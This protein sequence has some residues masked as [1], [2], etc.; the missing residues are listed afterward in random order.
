MAAANRTPAFVEDSELEVW[1]PVVGYEDRYHVS[2]LGR[3]KALSCRLDTWF[4]TRAR[5]ERIMKTR[6]DKAGYMKVCLQLNNAQKHTNV[7]V[8]VLKAFVGEPM[9]GQEARHLN[10]VRSD[11]RLSNLAWGNR[12]ENMQDQYL[13]G[14]RVAGEKHPRAKLTNELVSY[15]KTSPLLGVELAKE[16]GLGNSTISRVRRGRT[17][18]TQLGEQPSA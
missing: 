14:T 18:V 4:G 2:N 15:I 1:K 8:V 3:I 12:K 13:H 16:L 9:P 10:G 5:P 17:F 6:P 11:C 7:H